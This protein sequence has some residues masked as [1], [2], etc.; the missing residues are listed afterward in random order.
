MIDGAI[1]SLAVAIAATGIGFWGSVGIGS[2]LGMGQYWL[3]SSIH[4][5]DITLKGL[6]VSGLVGF[7][8]GA[9]SGAGAKNT[10]LINKQLAKDGVAKTGIKA[11][12]TA[13]NKMMNG[14]ISKRG[15]M[16]TFNLYGKSVMKSI[17]DATPGII[18]NR[19]TNNAL[20]VIVITAI[21]PFIIN[22]GN[23]IVIDV[24]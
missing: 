2:L 18:A 9:F 5:V 24:R 16:A 4:N 1:A 17:Q 10:T 15:F 11:L 21:S 13:A 6:I 12:T 7:V 8:L 22:I 19:L 23:S 14:E 3:S 20:K